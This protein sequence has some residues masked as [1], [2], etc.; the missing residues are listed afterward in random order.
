MKQMQQP[1]LHSTSLEHVLRGRGSGR[2]G[3]WRGGGGGGKVGRRMVANMTL[4]V[5]V[6]QELRTVHNADHL[7]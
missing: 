3:E 6:R 1:C 4:P 2:G 7:R 5:N